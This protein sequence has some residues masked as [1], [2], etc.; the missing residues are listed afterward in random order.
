MRLFTLITLVGALA[1]YGCDSDDDNNTDT[2]AETAGT[3][4]RPSGDD[5]PMGPGC[6]SGPPMH[7][8]D[9]SI[10]EADCAEPQL[11]AAIEAPDNG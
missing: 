7:M 9:C 10:A 5:R 8:C 3:Q 1:L 2:N 4:G 6:Y 11:D